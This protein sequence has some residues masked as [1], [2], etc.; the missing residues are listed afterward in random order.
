VVSATLVVILRA[1]ALP[2]LG[3]GLAA[4]AVRSRTD[5]QYVRRALDELGLPVLVGL[6]GLAVS[7]GTLGRL[8]AGPATALAHLN[9]VG[10]AAVT[11]SVLFNNLPAAS[12][13]AARAT[14]HPLALLIGLNLGPNL[15]VS[16]SLSW[17]LWLRT[18]RNAGAQP[19]LRKASGY[20]VSVVPLSVAAA[21]AALSLTTVR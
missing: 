17:L 5:R 1:P 11:T 19:S 7:L 10:T 9:T 4:S 8:W 21:L 2:V 15:F 18:A 14:A 20:G 13:L 12:L 16:G 3:V 6:F